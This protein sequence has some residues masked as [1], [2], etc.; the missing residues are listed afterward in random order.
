MIMYNTLMGVAAGSAQL[1]VAALADRLRRREPIAPEGW[2]LSFAVLGVILTVLGGAMTVTWPLTVNP[3]INVMFGEP[4]LVLG[5]LLLAAAAFMWAHP[6][7][8]DAGDEAVARLVRVMMPVAWLVFVLGLMLLS[9]TVAIFRFGFVGAAPAEEPISGLL[10][11]YPQAENTF[12]GLLYA[13]STVG[14]LLAPFAVRDP[15]G[16]VAQVAGWSMGVG[17]AAW[18]LFSVMNYYTHIGLL[19]NLLQKTR[20]EM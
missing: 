4:S 14:P 7:A 3:P 18:L 15:G 8:F 10:H 20:F 9:C 19:V 6:D 12:V 2:A 13:V 17:G 1:L 11:G 16:R 5:L